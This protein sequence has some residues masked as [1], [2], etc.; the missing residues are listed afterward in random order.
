MRGRWKGVTASALVALALGGYIG[1]I[2][3][4]GQDSVTSALKEREAE[5]GD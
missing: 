3:A 1:T 5:R 4:V 2:R